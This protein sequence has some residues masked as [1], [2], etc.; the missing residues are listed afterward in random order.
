[1]HDTA[2]WRKGGS[3]MVFYFEWVQV[4]SNRPEPVK[5]RPEL[6]TERLKPATERPKSQ[7][8]KG[9]QRPEIAS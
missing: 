2:P 4:T 3:K 9:S 5:E 1:M 6:A 7:L 8:L